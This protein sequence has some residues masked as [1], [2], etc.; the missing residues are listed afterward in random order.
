MEFI[1]AAR[2]GEQDRKGIHG[3]LLSWL[4]AHILESDMQYRDFVHPPEAPDQHE[5][6]RKVHTG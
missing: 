2:H 5:K 6:A 1:E 4:V 3:F